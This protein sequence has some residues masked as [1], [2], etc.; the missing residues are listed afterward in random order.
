MSYLVILDA[1]HGISPPTNGKRTPPFDD[2]TVM[3]EN[4]FNRDVVRRIDSMLENE[5]EVDVFFTTTE[6]RDINLDERV[7]RV[8]DLYK[9]VKPLYDKIVLV[10]VHANAIKDYWNDIANGTATFH[11]P[12]NEVDKKFAEVIQKNLIAK[13]GL[14]PH[15]GG[16]VAADFQ[17]IRDVLCTACLC[18]CA[19]MDNKEEAKLLISD[20]FRQACAEGI[21]NGLKEYFGMVKKIDVKYSVTEKGTYQLCGDVK[22]LGVKIVNKSNVSIEDPYCVNGTFFW[23]ATGNE[24]YSTSILYANGKLYQAAAN[25]LPC[26]QSVFIVYKDNTVDMKRIKNIAELDL[27]KVKLA[28][29]GIG[30]VNKFDNGFTYNPSAEGFVGTYSDVL[31]KTNKTVIGYNKKEN[32]VYLMAR[33][34]IYHSHLLYYDL[35]DLVKDCEYDI[36]LSVDGGGSTFFNNETDMVFKGN[37]RVIHNIIGFNL[38]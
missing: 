30:L 10:S 25:H 7:G 1:G 6:K 32:K 33:P 23:T 21:V 17:I 14:K 36:A 38:D 19:F 28:I 4:A 20:D 22:D 8:N 31:R 34:N 11:Y 3:Y 5:N 27:S 18:E 37:G 26:P 35:L 15:R 9:K 24:K 13:T 2:G 29:G 12:N 16:V